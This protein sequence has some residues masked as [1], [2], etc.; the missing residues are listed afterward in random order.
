MLSK[1][2]AYKC[3]NG[4][5][6]MDPVRAFAWKLSYRSTET[7]PMGSSTRLGFSECLWILNNRDLVKQVIES[8]EKELGE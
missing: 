5:L 4:Q 1:V 3:P 8:L 2:E 7:S 6:E